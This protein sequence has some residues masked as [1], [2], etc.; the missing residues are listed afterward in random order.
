MYF[1]LHALHVTHA[2]T[3]LFL[4]VVNFF[5][6]FF[7]VSIE[8]RVQILVFF[9]RLLLHVHTLLNFLLLLL[10]Q[11]IGLSFLH[12][13]DFFI[14]NH[15]LKSYL[16]FF[17][18]MGTCEQVLPAGFV[19][20]TKLVNLLLHRVVLRHCHPSVFVALQD[21]NLAIQFDVF[22]IQKVNLVL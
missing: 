7:S 15:L 19:F 3:Q 5:K 21:F 13:S 4:E 17:Q 8:C 20:E 9:S 2:V 16:S 11:L 22:F 10:H 14:L 6:E 1:L 18:L 12:H